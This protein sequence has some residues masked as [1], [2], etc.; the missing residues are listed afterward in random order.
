MALTLQKGG[1]LSLSKA[2]PSLT[3]IL[4]G[5]GWDPRATDGAEFDLDAS[6]FLLGPTAK[7]AVKPTSS[8]TTNCA[9]TA[10][11]AYRRQPYRRGRRR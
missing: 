9:G 11:R 2:D 7:S 4:V 10:R 8:S 5:L 1:N 6:A 3:R